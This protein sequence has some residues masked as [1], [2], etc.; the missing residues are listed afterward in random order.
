LTALESNGVPSWNVT[1]GRI[2]PVHSRASAL[3]S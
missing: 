2:L 1:P 3:A